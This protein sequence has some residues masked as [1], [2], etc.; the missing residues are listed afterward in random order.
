MFF[1][2]QGYFIRRKGDTAERSILKNITIANKYKSTLR[3]TIAR[4]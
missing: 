2:G 1:C 4:T 3:G